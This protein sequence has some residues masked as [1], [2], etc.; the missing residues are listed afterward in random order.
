MTHDI[1][2]YQVLADIVLVAHLVFIVFVL[3]GGLLLL[4]WQRLVWMHLPAMVWVVVV[5]VTG[6]VCPLTPLENYF[7]ARSGAD[8]YQ[9]D[10]IEHYLWLLIY[11]AQLTT[12]IQLMLAGVVIVFNLIIYTV[13]IR[14][15]N[16]SRHDCQH[17]LR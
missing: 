1:V 4:R 7:R 14:V 9:G 5:E 8:I 2:L 12:T 10:F 6:M 15:R 16:R 11:P 3:C 13:I 17:A